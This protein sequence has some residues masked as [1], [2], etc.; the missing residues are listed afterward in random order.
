MNGAWKSRVPVATGHVRFTLLHGGALAELNPLGTLRPM[1]KLS[2]VR[3]MFGPGLYLTQDPHVARAYVHKHSCKLYEFTLQGPKSGVLDLDL[4]TAD[5][6]VLPRYL[7]KIL[8]EPR[9]LGETRYD[10]LCETLTAAAGGDPSRI[11][12]RRHQLNQNLHRLGI[13]LF[14]LDSGMSGLLDRGVQFVLLDPKFVQ[15]IRVVAPGHL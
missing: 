5:S 2:P 8:R 1:S 14:H 3:S 12:H 11:D 9:V 7:P 4:E 6:H 10:Q 13:W 15:S